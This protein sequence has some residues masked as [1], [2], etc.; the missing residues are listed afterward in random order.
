MEFLWYSL[1]IFI[2]Y[3]Y[4]GFGLTFLLAPP[5]M[6]KY[7]I[8]FSPFIGLSYLSWCAWFFYNFTPWGSNYYA[9]W[10]LIPPTAFLILAIILKPQIYDKV[11]HFVKRENIAIFVLCLIVFL[12]ISMPYLVRFNGNLSNAITLKCGDIVS[13]AAISK[14]LT[15]SSLT[16]SNENVN[17]VIIDYF[18]HLIECNYFGAFVSTAVPSSF[19]SLETYQIQNLLTYLFFIFMIPIIFLICHKIFDYT[20]QMA[21]V[22]TAIC[23]LNFH[24]IYIIYQGFLG[25]IIGMGYFYCLFFLILYSLHNNQNFSSLLS[26]VPLIAFLW[27][28]F[29]ITYV[30]LAAIFMVPMLIYILYAIYTKKFIFTWLQ[31]LKFFSLIGIVSFLIFPT[32]YFGRIEE[33]LIFNQSAAG[34]E[35]SLIFPHWVFGFVGNTILVQGF[36]Y[37]PNLYYPFLV[38]LSIPVIIL[39]LLSIKKIYL[40]DRRLYL[41]STVYLFFII[42]LYV[43]FLFKEMYS[44]GISGDGYKSF[45]LLTYFIP[46]ILIIGLSYLKDCKII[47]YKS[48]RTKKQIFLIAIIICLLSVNAWSVIEIAKYNYDDSLSIS[49]NVLDLQ[50]INAMNDIDSVNILEPPWFNQMWTYYFLFADKKVHLKY[51][52][53]FTKTPLNGQWDLI[54]KEE[55]GKDDN[56][57]TVETRS[58]NSGYLLVKNLTYLD[59]GKGQ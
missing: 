51:T 14:F 23:G 10:I 44:P 25:Q 29:V 32:I 53:Y 12:I 4:S 36:Y 6:E 1:L 46:L 39:V 56:S 59:K 34:W 30:T 7:A 57:S 50:K 37:I 42:I 19:F 52:S 9:Y 5:K 48:P 24:L 45:K 16:N 18:N 20:P 58:L 3:I 33:L 47:H 8:F 22:V 31:L 27:F 54:N 2:F 35:M 41:L 28:G 38:L 26:Y 15:F 40:Q 17:N 13:Y 21:I 49:E 11:V 55:R 43:Y